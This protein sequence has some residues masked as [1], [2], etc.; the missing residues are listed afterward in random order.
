M[1]KTNNSLNVVKQLISNEIEKMVYRLWLSGRELFH[2]NM[3]SYL[4]EET[5]L[6]LGA[7]ITNYFLKLGQPALEEQ[8][9]SDPIVTR[10]DRCKNQSHEIR[11]IREYLNLDLIVLVKSSKCFCACE[12][13]NSDS[14]ELAS[15]CYFLVIENKFKS[16]PDNSQLNRYDTK[17]S[18]NFTSKSKKTQNK[19]F[20]TLWK[21]WQ[22]GEDLY[23]INGEPGDNA[24]INQCN[25]HKIS[26]FNFILTPYDVQ[27][28]GV[29]L[30]KPVSNWIPVYYDDLFVLLNKNIDSSKNTV[31]TFLKSYFGLTESIID[32]IKSAILDISSSSSAS[33]PVS[34]SCLDNITSISVSLRINDLIEKWRFKVL[35]VEWVSAI[36]NILDIPIQK[37]QNYFSSYSPFKNYNI[38]LYSET[39]FSRGTGMATIEIQPKYNNS[40]CCFYFGLQL[41]HNILKL[42]V[43]FL[44]SNGRN[45]NFDENLAKVMLFKLSQQITCLSFNAKNSQTFLNPG[46]SNQEVLSYF[47]P[48]GFRRLQAK[49]NKTSKNDDAWFFYVQNNLWAQHKYPSN[50]PGCPNWQSMDVQQLSEGLA[51]LI[52]SITNCHVLDGLRLIFEEVRPNRQCES[53]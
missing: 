37:G 5:D 52:K 19:I 7:E 27:V 1:H 21:Q 43:V 17:I 48:K 50:Q 29:S 36:G 51:N 9:Q 38:D 44:P 4:F 14:S 32:V 18:N 28:G 23:E 25:C 26:F 45:K 35:E 40:D 34:F 12:G 6:G 41:Q 31:P 15:D 11:V 53:L 3:L 8:G 47:L 30:F 20:E 22:V 33:F 42:F 39:N 13:N 46:N 2:S 10:C 16:L 49:S 24:I